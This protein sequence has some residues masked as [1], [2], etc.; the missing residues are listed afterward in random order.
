ME[1]GAFACD[2]IWLSGQSKNST[3]VYYQ[4][5]SMQQAGYISNADGWNE[6]NR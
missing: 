5:K 1:G 4:N 3:S 6:Y 2:P